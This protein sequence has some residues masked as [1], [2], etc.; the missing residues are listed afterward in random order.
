ML[1]SER[2]DTRAELLVFCVI[3]VWACNFPV[4]KYSISRLDTSVFNSIRYIVAALVLLPVFFLK[5][6]WVPL[7]RSDWPKLLRAGLVANVFYQ[8]A[9]IVGLSMTTAGN[10]AVLLATSPLWTVLI[11]AKIHKE[12]IMPRMY[13]GM[14][15]SLIG[16]VMI[17]AGS[18][19]KLEFGSNAI[20]GDLICVAAAVF[21]ATNTNLQ[22]P[23]LARYSALQLALV[24]IVIGALGLTI[25][26]VPSAVQMEWGSIHWTY[27]LGAVFSGALSIAFGNA[28]WSL[29]VK[30]LGPGRTANFGNLL[31]VL[32]F[33]ISYL[34][35]DEEIY[36][37]QVIGAA[38]TVAGVWISRR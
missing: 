31:P 19:K 17:I 2:K 3:V 8:I 36:T 11:N 24:M 9:F 4:A 38:V 22:K 33:I 18:G 1:P 5:S 20:V 21:W 15:V 34:V 26:A 35:I 12:R 14:A 25:I 13:F 27:Y 29:G 32:A 37:I 30:R 23:L 6:D 28:F 10:S 7:E 16:V